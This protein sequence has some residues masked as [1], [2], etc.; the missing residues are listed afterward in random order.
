VK[1]KI[2]SP[3]IE[4]DIERITQ[5]QRRLGKHGKVLVD[6]NQYWTS[7]EAVFHSLRLDKLN[8]GWVEEPILYTD[9]Q[10]HSRLKQTMRTP[11]ALGE[12]L[13][14]STQ[15]LEYLK[16]D[17][18]DIVQADVCFVGG[19]TEW[20]KIAHLANAFGKRVA[21]HFMMELSLHLLCGV[22]NAYMLENVKGGSL[23][24]LGILENPIVVEQAVGIPPDV[25]GH[26]I[27]FDSSAVKPYELNAE[28][29]RNRFKGG[30]K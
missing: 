24:E 1:I 5:V 3:D 10:G 6:A 4:R 17:A 2:G 8:L 14:S 15:I 18:V 23:T 16:A 29:V 7:S 30:S 25:P 28:Q 19:I 12:S 22:T 21:P 11:I 26:G 20:L 9:I 27:R 13:Y